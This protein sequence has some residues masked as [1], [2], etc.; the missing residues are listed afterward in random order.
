M[1][2]IFL[3]EL[4]KVALKAENKEQLFK[5]MVD[6][7]CLQISKNH[8]KEILDALWERENKMSTGIRTGVAVPHGKIKVLDRVYG[9]LGTSQ[10]GIS[11]DALDEQPVHLVFMILTPPKETESHLLILKRIAELLKDPQFYEELLSQT[12]PKGA[13]Q[14]LKKFEEELIGSL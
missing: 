5:E 10:K 2:E 3:P 8:N 1:H 12:D 4:T 11:Y 14:I 9:V 7:F 6:H 13:A